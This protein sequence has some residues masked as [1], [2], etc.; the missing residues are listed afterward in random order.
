MFLMLQGTVLEPNFGKSLDT[1][2]ANS[3]QRFQ[4]SSAPFS[5]WPQAVRDSVTSL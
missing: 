3:Q 4:S 2:N 1:E 5:I